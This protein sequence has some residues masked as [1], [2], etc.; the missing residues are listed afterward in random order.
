MSKYNGMEIAVIGMSGRFP[1]ANDVHQYWDNLKNGVESVS[2]FDEEELEKEGIEKRTLSNPS[3]V[4]ANSYLS[5][6]ENFDASFFGYRP[7]EARLMDPQVRLFHECVWSALEDAGCDIYDYDKKVGLF[8]GGASNM[9]WMN[10]ARIANRD[11]LVDSFSAGL[12]SDAKFLCTR[13]SYLFN[14]RGPSIHIET[15]CSTSLVAI[16]R[17]ALSLLLQECNMAIAGG[18][19]IKNRSKK[20]YFY[21]EG[22]INSHDGHCRAFDKEA[23]GTI[24][25]EGAG[26]VV[27]KRLQDAIKDGDQIHAIIKG[28]GVNNDGNNKVGYTAPSVDGQYQAI[29]KAQKMAKVA[30]ESISYLEAHGTA[31]VLGDPIEVEALN[32]AFGPS[33]EKYCALG[34]VKT[35]IGHLDAAAGIA[36]F[37]KAVLSIKNRQIP[38]SLHFKEPNPKINFENSPFYVN[39]ELKEWQNDQYPLRTG[40]SSFGIGGTN[41]HVILEE[42]PTAK[43]SSN[44]RPYQL[45]NVSAK[46][47]EALARNV[48]NLRTHL[49]LNPNINLADAAYSLKLGRSAFA[50]RKTF[51]SQDLEEA[52]TQLNGVDLDSISAVN[53]R[54]Q[55]VV[56]MFPGQGSQYLQM[57][58]E[59]YEKEKLFRTEVD[60]CFK[61]IEKDSGKDFSAVWF[62]DNSELLDTTAHTQPALFVVEYALAR[63]MM[64]WGISPDYMIGHSIGEYV[65]ACISGVFT[66]EDALKVVV[67]RGELMQQMA[68]GDMLSVS[69]TP[70]ELSGYLEKYGDVSLATVN[71]SALSVVSGGSD[72][73]AELKQ[74]LDSNGILNKVLNTSHAFHSAMMDDMLEDFQS[75]VSGI[76]RSSVTL[77]FISNLTG[78]PISDDE[79]TSPQYW[80][81]HLRQ[82]VQFAGG[83]EYLMDQEEELLFVEI[84]PGRGL[85]SFVGAH[86]AKKE[87]HQV[88]NLLRKTKG[89]EESLRQVLDGLGKLW[90]KGIKPDWK[91]FYSEEQRSK[92]SLPTYSFEQTKYPVDVDAYG[93]ISKMVTESISERSVVKK[94]LSEYFLVPSWEVSRVQRNQETEQGAYLN[95]LF[96]DNGGIGEQVSSLLGENLIIVK[97]GGKFEKRDNT[98]F[99]IK[100]EEE[101][102]FHQLFQNI[103]FAKGKIRIVFCWALTDDC[104][105]QLNESSVKQELNQGYFSLLNI[106]KSI[107]QYVKNQDIELIS[108]SNQIAKVFEGDEIAPGKSTSL[109]ALKVIPKEY[110]NFNCWNIDIKRSEVDAVLISRLAKD[111]ELGFQADETAYRQATRFVSVLRPEPVVT[112]GHANSF[113]DG[114]TYLITGGASGVGLSIVQNMARDISGANFVV[115]GRKPLPNTTEWQKCLSDF[116]RESPLYSTIEAFAEIEKNGNCVSYANPSI[117]DGKSLKQTIESIEK[118]TGQIQGVIHAAGIA[119]FAGVIHR[120]SRKDSEEVFEAKVFGTMA[121]QES[122]ANRPLDFFVLFSSLSSIIAPFGQVGYV[123]ANQFLDAFAAHHSSKNNARITS[124]GWNQW[125]GL[126]MAARELRKHGHKT[127]I[128]SISVDE[129]FEILRRSLAADRPGLFISKVDYK[130]FYDN[131]LKASAASVKEN[132][133]EI[134]L[135][136]VAGT[137]HSEL[138]I[139]DRLLV[140]WQNFFGKKDLTK[141]DGFFEIG[142]DSLQALTIINKINQ[143][144]NVDLSIA[145]FFENSSVRSLSG[146]IAALDETAYVEILEAPEKEYYALSSAQKRMYF[147]HEFDKQS[148]AYNMPQ[149]V[150]L[151][152]TLDKENL[153]ENFNKVITMHESLRTSFVVIDGEVFQKI[154]EQFDFDMAYFEAGEEE[155]K[156]IIKEF[157]RPFDLQKSPLIRVGLIKISADEHLLLIDMHHIISDGVS[158]GVF[159]SDFMALHNGQPLEKRSLQYKDYAEWQQSDQQQERLLGQRDF[160]LTQFKD[161][162]SV[163]DYPTDHVRPAIK[164]H[165]GGSLSFRLGKTETLGIRRISEEEGSTTFMTLLSIFNIL[166]SKISNQEDIVIG[167]PIAGRNHSDLE[168]IIGLFVNTLALRNHPKA[169]LPFRH[170]LKQVKQNTLACFDNQE[171]QYE[172][173]IEVLNVPRDASRNPLFDVMFGF[174]N[175][176]KGTV[177]VPDLKLSPFQS[178]HRTSRF[179]LM[180]TGAE[181]ADETYLNLEYALDLFTEESIHRFVSYFKRIVKAVVDNADI[182]IQSIDVLPSSEKDMLLHDFNDNRVVF[183]KEKTIVELLEEQVERTPNETAVV[184]GDEFITYAELNSRANELAMVLRE[185][186]VAPNMIVGLMV[187]RSFEMIIS[188]LAI[189]KS[190]GAYLAIDAD[191]PE[192]RVTYMLESSEV[193]VLMVDNSTITRLTQYQGNFLNVNEYTFSEQYVPNLPRVNKSDDLLYV[194]YTSGSTGRPKGVLIKH[195]N[196]TNLIEYQFNATNIDFSVV[197]QFA[198]LNFDVSFQ[199]IFSVV[200]GGGK[201]ILIDR[202]DL[203]DFNRLF[204]IIDKNA[205]KTIFMPASILNQIFN[206]VDSVGK[207]LKSISHIVTAGEQIIIGDTFKQ[208]LKENNVFLHNHYGSSET[209][210]VTAFTVDPN[211]EI[212][213]KPCIGYPIQ[214]T[215]IYIL[216][217]HQNLQPVNV[218]GELYSGGEQLG[219]GYLNNDELTNRKFIENPFKPGEKVYRTGD[220]TRW[221]PDGS[222][223]FLSRLDDQV[224]VRGFL[225]E[226]GDIEVQ[227]ASHDQIREVLVLAREIKGDKYLV[228][229][230]VSESELADADLR[231]FLSRKLPDYMLPHYFIHQDRFPLTPNGKVDR[232]ALPYP[233]VEMSAYVAPRNAMEEKLEEIWSDV[234]KRD[235]AEIGIRRSFFDLGGHSLK[236]MILVN[237]ILK[238]LEVSVPLRE[239]FTYQHIEGLAAY[240]TGLESTGYAP[241]VRAE[242]QE[243]YELSSAQRRMY[244]LHKLSPESL[245]YN[246]PQVVRLTG[247]IALSQLSDAFQRLV[248]RHQILRTSFVQGNSD[249]YQRI[250]K[251]PDFSVTFQ[252]V[253]ED[254]VEESIRDFMRP[255]DLSQGPLLR[256]SVL[257]LPEGDHLLMLD[258]HH[259]ITDGVSQKIL[260]REFMRLYQGETLGEVSLEYVDY[261]AWQNSPSEQSRITEHKRYWHEVFSGELTQLELPYDRARPLMRDHSGAT[262]GA[263]LNA[264]ERLVLEKLTEE[265]DG[266]MFMTLLSI[267]QVLLSKLSNQEDIIVGTPVAGRVHP[268]LDEMIGLF[269]N[270]IALRGNV[271]GDMLF[272]ELLEQV[273]SHTLAAFEHQSYQY[274]DLIDGLNLPR[275]TSR[276]PLFD[277]L[278]TLQQYESQSQQLP[279][280]SM[281][282]YPTGHQ[283]SKFDLTFTAVESPD[284]LSVY[285]QYSTAL[286]DQATIERFLAYFRKLITHLGTDQSVRLSELDILSE[287]E[288][289]TQL[290]VFNAT[291]KVYPNT[292]TLTSLFAERVEEAGDKVAILHNEAQMTYSELS[293]RSD[294]VASQLWSAGVRPGR[295]V[296]LLMDRSIDQIVGILGILKVG[297]AYLSLDVSHPKDRLSGM[298]GTSGATHLLTDGKGPDLS[299]VIA[300]AVIDIKALDSGS[301]KPSDWTLNEDH[302]L[303]AYIIFTSGSSGKPKGVKVSHQSVVNYITHQQDFFE[304]GEDERVLQFSRMTFDASVEQIWLSLLSGSTLVL[305]D[306]SVISDQQAF[307]SY[308]E[309]SSVTHLHATPS[310]LASLDLPGGMP[311]RRVVAGGEV[312]S[313]FVAARIAEHYDFYNKYGPTEATISVA[314]HKLRK[315]DLRM[316]SI[317]IGKPIRNTRLYVVGRNDELLPVGVYGELLIGGDGLAQ[318]YLEESTHGALLQDDPFKPDEQVYRTGDIVRWRGDGSLEY[319]GRLDDQVKLRGYRIELEEVAEV[320]R[321]HGSVE[322]STVSLQEFG[323]ERYMTGY[324]VSATGLS[325]E[326]LKDY[327]TSQLPSY[328][329]PYYI[330]P[331]ASMP[332]TTH[333]KVDKRALPRPE[334]GGESA[335]VAP[336]DELEEQLASIWSEVLGLE[337]EQISTQ[338]NFFEIGGTSLKVI[339]LS[340]QINERLSFNLPIASILRNPTIFSM[341]EFI[342]KEDIKIEELNKRIDDSVS[343]ADDTLKLLD[344]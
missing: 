61:L 257:T 124:I 225:I 79:A 194:I 110:T 45:I 239:I 185:K 190:G 218:A 343:E 313:S 82:T 176:K 295:V 233:D 156:R 36:G 297:G 259:I 193:A 192:E 195:S 47:P 324:Y 333:G 329:V 71:S 17:A 334:I 267:F 282:P 37:I 317:P 238:E 126:G 113:S 266:T 30:P 258:M 175:F 73:I 146:F 307:V 223:E 24:G 320:M 81:D 229:Y 8:A 38:P 183:S 310:Y 64:S 173:L 293:R 189:L 164:S 91:S 153:K 39:T 286:F 283:V 108:L 314:E 209:H 342:E 316:R 134:D 226:L 265:S 88:V 6:K 95:I 22:M 216:D 87:G 305:V 222:I 167:T 187:E 53:S 70:E 67:K 55:R 287:E 280:M 196:F 120:R 327:L 234:L 211:K 278:F 237:R 241:I 14:L 270:T 13:I 5:G 231:S 115:L 69:A 281:Q 149:V 275:D 248:M 127:S 219:L 51:V 147:I 23:S 103:D 138:S 141:E 235:R 1:G 158:Q 106:A 132:V 312:C 21:Q 54:N 15:A 72:Q 160:W 308:L 135:P 261:S 111:I 177:S 10:Y 188:M 46:T 11:H 186:G 301:E 341:K 251:D 83:V 309:S 210:V 56:F 339:L 29:L 44:S 284:Q 148:L 16:Q 205:V 326:A 102:D 90:T 74:E 144:F 344:Y 25:G 268:D 163:L 212:P 255:F 272:M 150:K 99:V 201:L 179:D 58:K 49:E 93:M 321:G 294:L 117:S 59:L 340:R 330:V 200:L 43:P 170:F 155:A 279:S 245:A 133:H 105:I 89:G 242:E 213:A 230:Y 63:L 311:L 332:L 208:Y 298:L 32:L 68:A 169:H 264:E 199:E 159:V 262:V 256:V 232:R 122:L 273:R 171:Y 289:Q 94:D 154:D 300:D 184:H 215:D 271:K 26:A 302:R 92:V 299:D 139:E 198:T 119:D 338:A 304:L 52:L 323:G 130:T 253:S 203:Q 12:L 143:Q 162:L 116:E 249:V 161:E 290:D 75:F 291:A 109:G 100:P 254:E 151:E 260:L 319:G 274:E 35:N 178:G 288:R 165:R 78:K 4:K 263:R 247:D 140:L 285:F 80:T 252:A 228:G 77:P 57:G 224:K 315:E 240:L 318:G 202:V 276:N 125:Q 207:N 41:A 204:H 112:D 3:Y 172:D 20:G 191:Y 236:A 292:S 227:L 217:K 337:A 7:D 296:G 97:Q 101:Q 328:M 28:S 128:D 123:A 107:S 303:L 244:F 336:S 62:A 325:S 166:L 197:L 50:Y 168:S 322:E 66:L 269:V 220:L 121:L 65:A 180:L 182:K 214:N 136:L 34:S 331:L 246:M 85:S 145:D 181:S 129:G 31:T 19:S 84:G 142:G 243:Q 137:D 18:V 40:V 98:S 250:E 60:Q 9:N 104:E 131:S 335:Y 27:L 33:K 174:L 42:A 306:Q 114:K 48:K 86:E 96:E 157:I 277:V 221:R 206:D 152:G 76:K 2:F 118:R